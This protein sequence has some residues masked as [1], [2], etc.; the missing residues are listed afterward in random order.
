MAGLRSLPEQ[1][2]RRPP[3]LARLYPGSLLLT[4]WRDAR[5]A[6]AAQQKEHGTLGEAA[7]N[8][9]KCVN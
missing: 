4:L 9:A 3:P 2:S 6:L 7:K 1:R 8:A 5:P